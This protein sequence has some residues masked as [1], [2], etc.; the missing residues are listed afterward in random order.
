MPDGGSPQ[1]LEIVTREDF[2][3]VTYS[4][5][6]HHPMMARAARPGSSSSSCRTSTAS[7]SR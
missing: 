6:I 2:S 7:A 5:E 3:D 1:Q 4:L